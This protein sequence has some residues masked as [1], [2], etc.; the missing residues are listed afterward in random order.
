MKYLIV[1]LLILGIIFASSGSSNLKGA[2][3]NLK[4]TTRSTISIGS[5]LSLVAGIVLGVI[6]GF[7]HF[8]FKSTQLIIKIVKIICAVLGILAILSGIVGILIFLF[9]PSIID[10]IMGF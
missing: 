6:A 10:G 5:I 9:A 8:M 4:E 7:L 2:I 1:T 3:E